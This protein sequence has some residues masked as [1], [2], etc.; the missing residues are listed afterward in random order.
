MDA[1]Q[2]STKVWHTHTHHKRK[3]VK[4]PSP[5]RHIALQHETRSL[6]LT[7]VIRICGEFHPV[8]QSSTDL[9]K[10]VYKLLPHIIPNLRTTK[11]LSWFQIQLMKQKRRASPERSPEKG[12]CLGVDAT[13]VEV[14]VRKR[15]CP[16]VSQICSFTFSPLISTV[17]ILKS[18]PIV[19]I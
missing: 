2:H 4:L 15:S 6:P 12:M 3:R 17:R 7:S 18:T 10:F 11:T 1:T 14:M 16:A 8:S 9:F 5:C 19:V 13:Y